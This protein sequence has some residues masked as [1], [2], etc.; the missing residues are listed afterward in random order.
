MSANTSSA[1]V[2]P[3]AGENIP[4]PLNTSGQE[5]T[6]KGILNLNNWLKVLGDAFSFDIGIEAPKYCIKKPDGST[7]CC[8]PQA[9]QDWSACGTGGGIVPGEAKWVWNR[10]DYAQWSN[11]TMSNHLQMDMSESATAGAYDLVTVDPSGVLTPVNTIC[12]CDIEAKMVHMRGGIYLA[13]YPEKFY[14]NIVR[15]AY[16]RYLDKDRL[17]PNLR[18]PE[19]PT[20]YFCL[21]KSI[22]EKTNYPP[23]IFH[24]KIEYNTSS[25]GAVDSLDLLKKD[26]S[27]EI[28]SCAESCAGAFAHPVSDV[29]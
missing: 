4:A 3:Q 20:Q 11:P 10:V 18:Y 26:F 7:S 8:P 27:Y 28:P 1:W 15:A 6:K 29:E 17:Y 25:S 2:E 14:P 16:C 22:S 24:G 21:F 19:L 5:Q 12:H 13:P 9:G 23:I